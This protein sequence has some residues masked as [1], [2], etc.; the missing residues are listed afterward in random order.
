M[1]VYQ[2]VLWM[3]LNLRLLGQQPR[4]QLSRENLIQYAARLENQYSRVCTHLMPGRRCEA[5]AI[6]CRIVGLLGLTEAAEPLPPRLLVL[7]ARHRR[8]RA[9]QVTPA[10][11][12]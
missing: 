6:A 8:K 3:L 1:T 9:A 4:F 2:Q 10:G 11:V 5:A 7:L 12:G